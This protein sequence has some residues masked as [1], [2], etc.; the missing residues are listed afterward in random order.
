MKLV[1][2]LL[3]V[4]LLTQSCVTLP[5]WGQAFGGFGFGPGFGSGYNAGHGYEFGNRQQPRR[6]HMQ[7]QHSMMSMVKNLASI[8]M[9]SHTLYDVAKTYFEP[10]GTPGAERWHSM[11]NRGN[12]ESSFAHVNRVTNTAAALYQHFLGVTDGLTVCVD[13]MGTAF[14]SIQAKIE[15]ITGDKDATTKAKSLTVVDEKFKE[16][17]TKLD[18]NS[19]VW[20]NKQEVLKE[21][22]DL[23]KDVTELGEST[24][25]QTT[26]RKL[27]LKW[28]PSK[29]GNK[30]AES[31]ARHTEYFKCLE[32]VVGKLKQEKLC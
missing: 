21:L 31:V 5:N 14:S 1:K 4:G 3:L 18:G 20:S 28:H 29:N 30:G 24:D 26:C 10:E 11:W 17:V 22:E 27:A 12:K 8:Y 19:P 13:Y 9:H 32:Q 7:A 23:Q 15:A 25:K 2:Q 6:P 16:F